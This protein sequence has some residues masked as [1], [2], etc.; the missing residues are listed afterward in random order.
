MPGEAVPPFDDAQV[1][2]LADWPTDQAW[3]SVIDHWDQFFTKAAKITSP[4]PIL[5]DM[6][7][8]RLA[9]RA[10]LDVSINNKVWYN[11]CSP[12]FYFDFAY[13]DHAYVIYANDL[14]GLHDRAARLLNSYCMETKDVPTGLISFPD[15][16]LQLGQTPDGLW[17]TRPGQF[18]AQGECL[19]A[20]VEHYKLSGDH[21]WLEQTAYPFIRKGAMWLVNSRHREMDRVKNPN[22]PRYG[23]IQ[24]NAMEVFSMTHGQH[25]Y[26]IDAWATLGLREASDAAA[27][28]GKM[29]DAKRFA[30]ESA[31]LKLAM[32]KSM[33]Q[34]FKRLSLYQGRTRR[35]RHVR[36]LGPHPAGLA[37]ALGR[38][39]RCH[40]RCHFQLHAA[41]RW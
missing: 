6:F 23:L 5:H 13:R 4:D 24:P 33:A 9:T 29:D 18:D 19:W 1:K 40:A 11:A 25:Q 34:T 20:L 37:H 3:Q 36:I 12:W 28:L 31:D 27:A 8:S 41:P 2:K 7:L 22:D 38:S 35:R 26:Y 30:Q 39:T 17:L 21:T 15:K 10:I 14:A 32:R 16:P